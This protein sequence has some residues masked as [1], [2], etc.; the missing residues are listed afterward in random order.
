MQ[1]A[2]DFLMKSTINASSLQLKFD[3][4][5]MFISHAAFFISFLNKAEQKDPRSN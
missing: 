3:V 2:K 5:E 4:Q 1:K